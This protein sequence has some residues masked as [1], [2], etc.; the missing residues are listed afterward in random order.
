MSPRYR[1]TDPGKPVA[2]I[3]IHEGKYRQVKK[4]VA[5]IGGRVVE[6]VATLSSLSID[7]PEAARGY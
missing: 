5:G 1:S 6:H 2:Q 7:R 3:T 4:M